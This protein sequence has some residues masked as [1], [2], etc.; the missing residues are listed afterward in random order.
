[1]NIDLK[2]IENAGTPQDVYDVYK[3]VK[4]FY[5][6]ED[7]K[8]WKDNRK[9]NWSAAY[10][11]DTEEEGIWTA[12]EKEAMLK[13]DQIPIGI[14]DLAKGVQGSC[15]V[16]TAKAPGL[17]FVPIGSSDLYVAELF[18]RG[19]DHVISRNGGPI[20]FYDWVQETKVGALGCLEAKHDAS[21]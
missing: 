6:D 17:N 10:P 21:K 2:K 19:C 9:K 16:I 1:M 13:K 4:R 14:N 3:R 8:I 18:K 15:A 20:I 12:K 5:E 11:L 7:R